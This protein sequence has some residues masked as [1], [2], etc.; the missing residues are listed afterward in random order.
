[1][2]A[3]NI[4]DRT[5][6]IKI[7]VQ[8]TEPA[9]DSK[10]GEMYDKIVTRY[11]DVEFAPGERLDMRNYAKPRTPM[12]TVEMLSGGRVVPI[13]DPRAVAY[14]TQRQADEA[15]RTSA[16]KTAETSESVAVPSPSPSTESPPDPPPKSSPEPTE[17]RTAKSTPNHGKH[18][19]SSAGNKPK[20]SSQNRR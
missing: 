13:S 8:D 18:R 19:S 3:I 5:V 2:E 4:S 12:S 17:S 11:Q 16:A 20:N 15:E 1:M 9:R 6:V 14:L 10:T 7:A